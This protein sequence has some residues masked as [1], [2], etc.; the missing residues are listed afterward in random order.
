MLKFNSLIYQFRFQS[1]S[2]ACQVEC[3][4]VA[5]VFV[6]LNRPAPKIEIETNLNDGNC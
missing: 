4:N 6:P 2:N 5:E 3:A 1:L